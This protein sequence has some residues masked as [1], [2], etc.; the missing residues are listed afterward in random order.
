MRTYAD[1][2]VVH[3]SR[4]ALDQSLAFVKF[5]DWRRLTFFLGIPTL[6]ALYGASANLGALEAD[7][8]WVTLQFYIAHSYVPWWMTC[9]S[10]RIAYI[11]LARLQP[12]APLLWVIGASVSCLLLIPYLSWV[13]T[14]IPGGPAAGGDHLSITHFFI[15]ASR[16]M[17]IWV[18]ANYIFDY[19]VGLPRYRYPQAAVLPLTPSVEQTDHMVNKAAIEAPK[20]PEF[21][22][23]SGKV[24]SVEDLYSVSAEEHYVRI[25]T[26]SGDELIY[27]RFA[28]AVKELSALSGMRIH[29]S[30]WVAP[31][32]VKDV[33]REGKRMFIRL[34]DGTQLPV[35]RPYQSMVRSTARGCGHPSHSVAEVH[36]P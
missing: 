24:N 36:L 16:I 29:R 17:V 4:E 23:K 33:V 32:A 25:H 11:L 1:R 20:I 14:Q 22:L 3:T 26:A 35:S 9:L 6:L 5:S 2:K 13:G 7:G 10:T 28:D 34:K 27:K 31:C 15:H 12:A 21:L 19:F 8:I 30:H 18:F